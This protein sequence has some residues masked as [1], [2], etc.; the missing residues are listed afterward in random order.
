MN[1]VYLAAPY[2]D[3]N[4]AVRE[5]RYSMTN[6]FAARLMEA[7]FSVFSPI[8]Q[9]HEIARYLPPALLMDHDHWMRMDLPILSRAQ[10]LVVLKLP[11]WEKSRGVDAELRHA[12]ERGIPTAFMRYDTLAVADNLRDTGLLFMGDTDLR[13]SS[14]T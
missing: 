2:T 8:S 7:G 1:Y 13:V 14:E 5:L 12:R 4:P 6:Q 10:L 11:G 9:S 3:E